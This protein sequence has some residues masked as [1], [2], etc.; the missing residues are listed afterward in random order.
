MEPLSPILGPQARICPD[1]VTAFPEPN[2]TL[3]SAR[4][5]RD[6]VIGSQRDAFRRLNA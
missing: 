3:T 1:G 5:G 6:D 4:A 2:P